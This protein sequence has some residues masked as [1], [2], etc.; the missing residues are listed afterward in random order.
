M[1]KNRVVSVVNIVLFLLIAWGAYEFITALSQQQV[2]QI[3]QR[4]DGPTTTLTTPPPVN[5]PCVLMPETRDDCP[6]RKI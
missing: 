6:L 3:R 2:D 1:N 5:S 4:M